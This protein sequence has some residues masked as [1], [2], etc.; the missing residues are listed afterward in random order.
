MNNKR[1]DKGNTIPHVMALCVTLSKLLFFFSLRQKH[2]HTLQ[3]RE[4]GLDNC[5][6]LHRKQVLFYQMHFFFTKSVFSGTND[7]EQR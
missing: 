4:P 7:V 6:F 3:Y 5:Y 2:L 1:K